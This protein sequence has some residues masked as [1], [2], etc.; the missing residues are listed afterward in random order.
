MPPR[1]RLFTA[2]EYGRMAEAGILSEDDRVELIKG[3]IVQMPAIGSLHAATVSRLTTLF[4]L[5]LGE[6]AVVWPRNPLHL[7]QYSE[8]EPDLCLLRAGPT[9]TAR[10][11]PARRMCCWSS[12]STTVP[13]ATTARSSSRSTQ[14]S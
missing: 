1:P 7:D 8:P 14:R 10:T 6:K 13:S 12:R 2:E 3:E 11:T 4:V 9:S 5:S